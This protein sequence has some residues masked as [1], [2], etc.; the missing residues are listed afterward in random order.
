MRFSDGD[1]V[2]SALDVTPLADGATTQCAICLDESHPD[3]TEAALACGHT[4]HGACIRQWLAKSDTCPLC[5]TPVRAAL[6]A[7]AEERGWKGAGKGADVTVPMDDDEEEGEAM[8]T[9]TTRP[10]GGNDPTAPGAADVA[11][12]LPAMA[13]DTVVVIRPSGFDH[14]PVAPPAVAA[15]VPSA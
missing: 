14:P 7:A 5:A 12:A 15:G 8:A 6:F 10:A 4:Y 2:A 13:P 9:A 1:A 11:A 3:R